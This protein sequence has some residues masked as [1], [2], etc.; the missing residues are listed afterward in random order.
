M[1]FGSRGGECAHKTMDIP[2]N[3]THPFG[4][5]LGLYRQKG[6]GGPQL[7]CWNNFKSRYLRKLFWNSLIYCLPNE[8]IDFLLSKS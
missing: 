4:V 7:I 3:L 5:Q 6:G 1:R 2:L 8:Y